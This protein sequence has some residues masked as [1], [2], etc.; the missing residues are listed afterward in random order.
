M[1]DLIFRMSGE[2]FG[3]LINGIEIRNLCIWKLYL[4]EISF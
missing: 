3:Y 2:N 4:I 1:I